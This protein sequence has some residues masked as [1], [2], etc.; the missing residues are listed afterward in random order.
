VRKYGVS[1]F[2]ALNAMRLPPNLFRG[3][4]RGL[5]E[6][7]QLL[8]PPIAPLRFAEGGLVA[9]PAGNNLAALAGGE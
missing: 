1:V 9:A 4:S 8:M 5:V 6:R 7:L 2:H 3:F